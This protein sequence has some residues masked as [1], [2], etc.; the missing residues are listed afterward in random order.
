[1]WWN[2]A[3]LHLFY[4]KSIDPLKTLVIHIYNIIFQLYLK[5]LNLSLHNLHFSSLLMLMHH[6]YGKQEGSEAWS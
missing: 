1:M 4:V 3:P 2:S 6:I 5:I